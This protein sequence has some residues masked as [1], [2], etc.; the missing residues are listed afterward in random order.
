MLSSLVTRSGLELHI[1]IVVVC[2]LFLAEVRSLLN[3]SRDIAETLSAIPRPG[4]TDDHQP[5]TT[6]QTPLHKQNNNILT[7]LSINTL[8]T[9]QHRPKLTST[10]PNFSS[11][12]KPQNISTS[13]DNIEEEDLSGLY[14]FKMRKMRKRTCICIQN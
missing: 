1:F 3:L 6:N 10:T 14:Q 9:P 8:S 12:P 2:F 5:R 7:T 13:F 4:N 11:T